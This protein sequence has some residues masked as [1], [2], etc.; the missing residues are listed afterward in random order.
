VHPTGSLTEEMELSLF[1]VRNYT[2]WL[3]VEVLFRAALR[4]MSGSGRGD[5]KEE[6]ALRE[7]VPVPR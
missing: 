7:R 4:L 6:A 2:I 1:Y 3:D 5:S